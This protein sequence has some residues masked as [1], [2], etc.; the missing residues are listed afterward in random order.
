MNYKK[1]VAGLLALTFAFGGAALPNTVVNS[2]VVASASSYDTYG[3]FIYTKLE[4]GTVEILRYRGSD[5]MVKIPSKING[6]VVTRINDGTF[7]GFECLKNVVLPDTVTSIGSAAFQSCYNLEK[8]E[9]PDS[10]TSIGQA[11]FIGC[12]NLESVT[13]SKNLSTIET[14]TFVDC[15]SLESITL[16]DSVKELGDGVFVRCESLTDIKL[17][18]NLE[19]IGKEVF[20][21][22]SNL[23]SVTIP[24]SVTE[25]GENAFSSYDSE[26]EKFIP[27]NDLVVKCYKDSAAH[28]YVLKSGNRFKV[29]D[30]NGSK[31][32]YPV[33]IKQEYNAIYRQFRVT[34]TE[35]EGAEEY[36]IAVKLAGKWRI[37]ARTNKTTF[38]SPKLSSGQSYQLL[39]CAKVNGKWDTSNITKMAFNVIIQ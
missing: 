33:L 23:K 13:L 5:E 4:N 39:I 9:I 31:T 36:G 12:F 17:S 14:A 16:P 24:S 30:A 26:T 22:C 34:W 32:K 1:I 2:S 21:N 6:V 15:K 25:I 38:T 27:I 28:K 3:D 18:K 11:A 35:V 7:C 8:I 10:V 29:I 37:Q 20:K 19:S